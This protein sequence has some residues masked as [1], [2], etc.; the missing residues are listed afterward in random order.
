MQIAG[1]Y[2]DVSWHNL[3]LVETFLT[4]PHTILYTGVAMVLIP[5]LFG[6]TMRFT[7]F[8]KSP[9]KYLLTG[10]LIAL[11]GGVSQLIAG[12]FDFWW[13]QNF[14]FDPF[15][16][17]PSH[18]LLIVGIALSGFGMS[19]GSVRLL[20]AHRANLGL[21]SFLVSSRWL[22][23]LVIMA[24]TA[25]WLDLN[26]IVYLMMDEEGIAYTFQL[27]SS[28]VDQTSSITF[29]TGVI[30]VAIPGT[31]IFFSAK[32]ILGWRGAVTG[33]AL[34]SATISATANLGFTASVLAGSGTGPAVAQFIPLYLLFIVPVAIFDFIIKPTQNRPRMI[35]AAVLVS[36]FASFLD[37]WYS[38][39]L[40]A[41][42]IQLVPLLIAPILAVGLAAGLYWTKF[43][44]VLLAR[45]ILRPHLPTTTV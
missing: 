3:G 9:E 30:L 19:I 32:S 13:H 20:Q 7:S 18:S 6:L 29:A 26:S 11:G 37:G 27:G 39:A 10:F 15:L 16:F 24:L 8:R 14:G 17:T 33:I 36:P 22:Q 23:A 41:F 28:F 31:L 12:P 2:W 42:E 25:L 43:T 45:E 44:N 21:G 4:L 38:V 5:A 40:W 34:L 35:F 1:G